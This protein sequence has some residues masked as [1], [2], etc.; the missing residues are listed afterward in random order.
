[1]KGGVPSAID[2]AG[3]I[4]HVEITDASQ[5]DD[6]AIEKSM[7][8]EGTVFWGMGSFCSSCNLRRMYWPEFRN[9]EME[10][11]MTYLNAF[12]DATLLN[13]DILIACALQI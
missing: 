12:P 10:G 7:V 2:G 8:V 3:E 11:M 9:H 5:I 4:P 6:I 13:P 1:V